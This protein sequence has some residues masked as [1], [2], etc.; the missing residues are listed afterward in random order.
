ML[1]HFCYFCAKH[2][3]RFFFQIFDS[4]LLTLDTD[5]FSKTKVF[6]KNLRYLKNRKTLLT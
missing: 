4:T 6:P 1:T 3:K 5:R 2:V